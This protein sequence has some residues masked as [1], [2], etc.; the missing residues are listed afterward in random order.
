M[1]RL[2]TNHDKYLSNCQTMK[3]H[4]SKYGS[5]DDRKKERKSS[6][7]KKERRTPVFLPA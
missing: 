3:I 1:S 6:G 2:I 4:Y 7:S 5:V